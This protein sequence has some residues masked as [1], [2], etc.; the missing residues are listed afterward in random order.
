[1]GFGGCLG[2]YVGVISAYIGGEL[3]GWLGN[4]PER[5]GVQLGISFGSTRELSGVKL[6]VHWVLQ[7]KVC[8][9]KLRLVLNCIGGY[10]SVNS[11]LDQG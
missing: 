8:G 2:I 1:M 7:R 6:C 3:A 11:G 5:E 10:T 9:V 4:K